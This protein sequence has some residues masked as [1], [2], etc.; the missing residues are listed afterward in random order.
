M[1]DKWREQTGALCAGNSRL[2]FAVACAFAG[3][4]LRPARM[5]SA[6]FHYRGDSSSGKT[7]DIS[8]RYSIPRSA[9][10]KVSLGLTIM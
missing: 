4:L 2:V 9:M 8:K 1:L 5:E 3:P 10:L 7:I 6:G